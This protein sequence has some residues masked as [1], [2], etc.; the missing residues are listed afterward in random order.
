MCQFCHQHGEGEK[1]YLKAE[2][3]SQDLLADLG[4]RR[5]IRDFILDVGNGHVA[6]LENKFHIGMQ[7]PSWLRQLF[8]WFTERRYRRD[9]F[10]Q[11][12]PLEDLEQVLDLT[13]SIVRLPCICRKNTTGK[14]DARYCF[15]LSLD[16][17][18]VLE[19]KDAFLATFQPGPDVEL[20]EYL[21]KA[22]APELLKSYE[23]ESLIHSLW[24]FKTPFIGGLCNCDRADCLAMVMNRYGLRLFFRAEYVAQTAEEDCSGCRSCLPTCQFGAI[25][26]SATRQLAFIDPLRC[27][28][29]GVCRSHCD[30]RAI[31]LTPRIQH[32]L[33]RR[34]W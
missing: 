17:E 34:I 14:S 15:G 29:C 25:G 27:Y 23:R 11:V 13:T 20:F 12:V 1:W 2:H 9:H 5:F 4:R 7:A 28:G 32:P 26:F 19:I 10:G 33:A 30:S 6:Q 31:H 18:K 3:Y 24:T 22:E 21:N 16:P 8:Y